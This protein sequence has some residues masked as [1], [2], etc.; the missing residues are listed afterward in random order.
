MK[1]KAFTL[2]E[3][4]IV[5]TIVG[6][7]IGGSFKLLKYQREKTK[8]NE[9][10]EIV[11]SA[12]NAII[13]N[14]A[15]NGN[16]LPDSDYFDENLSPVT[17]NE[18]P[19]LYVYDNNLTMNDACT[20]S[21]TSL[22]VHT[23]DKNISDIAFVVVS[24]SANYNMQTAYSGGVVTLHD[25]SEEVDDNTSPIN[26]VESYDDVYQWVTLSELQNFVDCSAEQIQI[27]TPNA[28]PSDVNSSVSYLGT[29]SALIV[30]DGGSRYPDGDGDGQDDYKWCVEYKSDNN[31]TVENNATTPATPV[32]DCS[33]G[34]YT[35]ATSVV[36]DATPN[37]MGPGVY[38]LR[39]R[40]RDRIRI[41]T[42]QFSIVINTA[43]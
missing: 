5:L 22:S 23:P 6:L 41:I 36:V 19:L 13:G 29:S 25:P 17:N 15:L 28:L 10:K 8:I 31:I 18:H 33:T 9:A 7:M 40:V 16:T 3:L 37:S 27:V 32:Q 21:S 43:P 12:K 38:Y 30:A 20:V 4:A 14:T 39:L 42:K 2:I 11:L 35:Q 34:L 1:R 24:E 26:R